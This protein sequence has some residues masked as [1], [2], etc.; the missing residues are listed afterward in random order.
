V[1]ITATEGFSC[2]TCIEEG[3]KS[4]LMPVEPEGSSTSH[5]G[6]DP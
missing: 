1:S 6:S 5:P 2:S 3:S 4:S